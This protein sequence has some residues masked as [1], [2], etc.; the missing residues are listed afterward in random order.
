MKALKLPER[1]NFMKLRS[2]K[3]AMYVGVAMVMFLSPIVPN[4]VDA[5]PTYEQQQSTLNNNEL[6]EASYTEN[7]SDIVAT[8]YSSEETGMYADM[9]VSIDTD[10]MEVY[11][12]ADETSAVTGRLYGNSIMNVV[13]VC[14]DW[15]QIISRNLSGYVRTSTLCFNEEA[16]ALAEG[17]DV[18]VKVT[19]ENANVYANTD[20]TTVLCTATAGTEYIAT[21][22]CGEYILVSVDGAGAYIL[23]SDVETQYTFE[24]GM[25]NAEVEAKLAAE[26][27]A[28]AER[29]AREEAARK[30][31]A[32]A[33]RI[34]ANKIT[35]PITYNEPV[36]ATEEEIW[37]LACLIDWEAGWEPYEGKLA[38]ANIVLNRVKDS[39]FKAY[40]IT[41]VIYAPGQFTG[42]TNGDRKPSTRFQGYLDR[43]PRT[44]DCLK[45]A[46]EA[47][48]GKNNMG[49]FV[50]FRSLKKANYAAYSKYT[51]IGNHC[52]FG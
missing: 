33:A 18:T 27:K 50:N 20:G 40:T 46:K 22:R 34:A 42:V 14:G 12:Q 2:S 45:A 10:Y 3:A 38:V 9:A 16:E 31:A 51:V 11:E 48:A 47:L 29:K 19:A 36:S 5:K 6:K 26:A 32:E 15:T 8:G 41:D 28:E 37:L 23:A 52:F 39:R 44:E 49:S 43:G 25:N 21:S 24:W 30:A 17:A 7:V 13:E 4:V 1:E 35:V